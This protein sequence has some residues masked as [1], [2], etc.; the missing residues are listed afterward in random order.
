M[1]TKRLAPRRES[2]LS[3]ARQRAGAESTEVGSLNLDTARGNGGG[4]SGC[5]CCCPGGLLT[6]RQPLECQ[7]RPRGSCGGRPRDVGAGQRLADRPR[8]Q[9]A[10]RRT[11][12]GVELQMGLS[13]CQPSELPD[14]T[15]ST[16]FRSTQENFE[17]CGWVLRLVPAE[18]ENL[19]KMGLVDVFLGSSSVN[20]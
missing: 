20:G 1:Q 15:W 12:P 3:S 6:S 17:E 19:S 14:K 16:F 5:L 2:V 4:V 10:P 7:G 11:L 13:H 8:S 9:N 18:K